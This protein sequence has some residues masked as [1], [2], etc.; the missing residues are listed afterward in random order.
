MNSPLLSCTLFLVTWFLPLVWVS[1]ANG[2]LSLTGKGAP[3]SLHRHWLVSENNPCLAQTEDRATPVPCPYQQNSLESSARST[4][5]PIT[6]ASGFLNPLVFPQLPG[7]ALLS[8]LRQKAGKP[9]ETV[10][11]FPC[12][13]R[14]GMLEKG[15][16][17]RLQADPE[18]LGLPCSGGRTWP[19]VH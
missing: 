4:P 14:W 6:S 1:V 5:L 19:C 2:R 3:N 18:E 11:Q 10:Q 15:G 7:L 8:G 16:W 13:R 9:P 17:G 12:K